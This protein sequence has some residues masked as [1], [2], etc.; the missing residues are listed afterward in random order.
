MRYVFIVCLFLMGCNSQDSEPTAVQYG[1]SIDKAR[2]VAAAHDLCGSVVLHHSR[3]EDETTDICS[4]PYKPYYINEF[5]SHETNNGCAETELQGMEQDLPGQHYNVL[6]F[7]AGLHDFQVGT[8]NH[9]CGN[10]TPESFRA[11]L[12]KIADF[13]QFHADYVIWIDTPPI[14]PSQFAIPAGIQDVINPIGDEVAREHGFYILEMPIDPSYHN[15][16]DVH[17]NGVG[18]GIMGRWEADCVLTVLS[19]GETELCH[20]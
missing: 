3:F 11:A 20:R 17:Y 10:S 18:Y 4:V 2:T 5:L 7:T 6:I 15:P 12:E 13:A 8:T 16:N 9:T 19:G 14:T 1:D